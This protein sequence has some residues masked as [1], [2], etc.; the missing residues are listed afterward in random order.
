[1][2][3]LLISVTKHCMTETVFFL[4]FKVIIIFEFFT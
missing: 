2:G 3:E 1:M 4:F